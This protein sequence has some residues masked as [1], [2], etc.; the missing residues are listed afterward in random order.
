MDDAKALVAEFRG[1]DPK[2]Q[3]ELSPKG[4]KLSRADLATA[5]QKRLEGRLDSTPY[6]YQ[7]QTNLCGEAAFLYCLIKDRPDHYV[8]FAI[9]L[10]QNAEFNLKN[11]Q[12]GLDFWVRPGQG[13]IDALP[14][15]GQ[16][17]INQLDWLMMGSL[18]KPDRGNAAIDDSLS[19]IT[20]PDALSSWFEAV[21][22]PKVLR[23]FNQIFGGNLNT[24]KQCAGHSADSWA[25]VEIK[26]SIIQ[27]VDNNFLERHWVVLGYPAFFSLGNSCVPP[28]MITKDNYSK[29]TLSIPVITWGFEGW[30]Y[31]FKV[32]GKDGLPVDPTIEE[33]L[34]YFVGAFVF[35]GIPQTQ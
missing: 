2:Q 1:A 4:W 18:S 16:A 33:F 23:S 22:S 7:G 28:Q 17:G 5:L 24:F 3:N 32:R 19:A 26:P 15:P 25:I 29:I 11:G 8:K 10:W 6:P 27:G 13:T 20:W 31:Q 35:P 21:G 12:K 14:M 34:D 30:K 9:G